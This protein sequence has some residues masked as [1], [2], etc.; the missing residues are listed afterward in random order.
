MFVKI[1]RLGF[2]RNDML[3]SKNL[4]LSVPPAS[5]VFYVS[6]LDRAQMIVANAKALGV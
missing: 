4:H 2:R 1:R 5:D 3:L 6:G